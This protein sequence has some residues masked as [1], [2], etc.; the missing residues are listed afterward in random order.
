M[1]KTKRSQN[2]KKKTIRNILICAAI[3][4]VIALV[5]F[6]TIALQK[7]SA[8]M[9]CFQRRATVASAHGEKIT[10]AEYRVAYDSYG[11]YYI[12][13]QNW[14]PEDIAKNLLQDKINTTE[15]K[16]LGLSLT[17]E[18]EET[19][20]AAAQ[21]QIDGI[22]KAQTDALI[23]N[24]SY[25][26]TALEKQM[27]D[28]YDRLGMNES[29]YY[30]FLKNSYAALYYS[31]KL[32]AYYTE[33]GSGIDEE[34][35][36][37]FYRSEVEKTMKTTDEN[38]NE[39]VAYRDGQ[40]W[41]ALKTYFSYSSAGMLPMLYVPENFIYI[42]YIKIQGATTEEVTEI[43]QQVAEGKKSFDE[44]MNSDDNK[45]EYR[46]KLEGPYPIAEYDHN[47]LFASQEA[48]KTAEALQVG[49]IGYFVENATTAEDGTQTVT[50]YLF[51]RAKGT[52]CIDGEYGVIKMDLFPNIRAYFEKQYRA[53]QWFADVKYE[54]ALY[55]YKGALG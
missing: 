38:G 52:M 2:S 42:D 55:A 9:T 28:V 34:T 41:T 53:A 18:E 12:Q 16:A 46:E 26:K 23:Q 25:S 37:N 10:M 54:D 31:E 40:F 17:Q 49:E 11:A 19:C 8:G 27:A 44:L 6:L 1:S 47:E 4:V 3:A 50:A 45:S 36:Q 21:A 22:R 33:N 13:T 14:T 51:R 43:A 29:E 39:T 48:Y 35:L 30:T 15:A 24:G 5:V 20:K 32:E 7:D